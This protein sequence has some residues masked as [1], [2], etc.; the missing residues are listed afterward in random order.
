MANNFS[1]E[2]SLVAQWLFEPPSVLSD[3]SGNSNTI[4]NGSYVYQRTDYKEGT[5]SLSFEPSSPNPAYAYLSDASLSSN[6]PLK[7]SGSQRS[8]TVTMWVKATSLPLASGDYCLLF[9]KESHY[10]PDPDGYNRS[11]GFS[12]AIFTYGGA[13]SPPSYFQLRM[14]RLNVGWTIDEFMHGT[15]L[16]ADRWYHVAATFNAS[17]K[18]YRLRIFDSVEDL[19]LDSDVTGTYGYDLA[20][21]TDPV[22]LGADS[23]PNMDHTFS[24]KLDEVLVFNKALSTAE[25]D[26]VRSQCF[27]NGIPPVRVNTPSP[28]NNAIEQ[29]V[30]SNISWVD[31]GGAT[32]FKVYFGT[33]YPLTESDLVSTQSSEN[34]TYDPGQLSPITRYYWRINSVNENG[35]TTG[36]TFVFYTGWP[37]G[38]PATY[39]VDGENG[40]NSNDGY[41]SYSAWETIQY[42]IDQLSPGDTL[43]IIE[44]VYHP[45]EQ[46]YVNCVGT[47]E[48]QITIQAYQDGE[49]I[50]DPS[51]PLTGWEAASIDD[52]NLNIGGSVNPDWEN[53]YT[54]IS[55][56]IVDINGLYEDGI[57]MIPAT[58]PHQSNK[59]WF[60]V[61]EMFPIPDEGGN[62]GSQAGQ[63]NTFHMVDSTNLIQGTDDYWNGAEIAIWRHGNGLSNVVVTAHISDYDA[64]ENKITITNPDGNAGLGT[65]FDNTG[66]EPDAYT[67]FNHPMIIDRPGAWACVDLGDGTYKI[68]LWPLNVD[69]LDAK[70][71]KYNPACATNGAGMF[72]SYR[73]LLGH[74]T[75]FKGITIRNAN[76]GFEFARW[77]DSNLSSQFNGL[78]FINCSVIESSGDGWYVYDCADLVIT[79]CTVEN[80]GASAVSLLGACTNSRTTYNTFSNLGGC[81][82]YC[83]GSPYRTGVWGNTFGRLGTH[84]NACSMYSGERYLFANNYVDTGSTGVTVNSPAH[85]LTVWGNIFVDCSSAY[86]P[87]SISAGQVLI[88]HNTMINCGVYGSQGPSTQISMCNILSGN[89]FS[90][91]TYHD[92]NI[93]TS[94]LTYPAD[95]SDINTH[96]AVTTAASLFRNYASGDYR[97]SEN[98]LAKGFGIEI[99]SE[100][101]SSVEEDFPDF[102]FTKDAWSTPCLRSDP[103]SI[104]AYEYQLSDP[105]E[106]GRIIILRRSSGKIVMEGDSIQLYVVVD[107]SSTPY[108]Q[109]YKNGEILE[110]ETSDILTI[111]QAIFGDSGDQGIYT[112]SVTLA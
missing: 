80:M 86:A 96:E 27:P 68:Y 81:G 77:V 67:I 60:Y 97:L 103:P 15:A 83:S 107:S 109:W 66:S 74:Y 99:P 65:S 19:V 100:Y 48:D 55:N 62:Y 63:P 44:G 18:E 90:K 51:L 25:I 75:T 64:S 53:I 30:D 106:E 102:D 9:A 35:T 47:D 36:T 61:E 45:A 79:G 32:Q 56:S 108:Y 11:P 52:P 21:N 92:Y 26:E 76:S 50:I 70:I 101:L 49:V 4:T 112:C 111:S 40:D 73:S 7:S 89:E 57:R 46:I 87:W 20:V 17:T 31:G 85:I 42:A 33:E 22:T 82:L 105:V 13:E 84:G 8:I 58:W 38:L 2:T 88:A 72:M 37:E 3:S 98:S 54:C 23:H 14:G 6:F 59:T 69:D 91:G 43:N 29:S 93:F 12:V 95:P 5:Q 41:H 78:E 16:V 28:A 94:E 71:R 10:K 24:G 34:T 1:S 104:G 39:Y 110:G